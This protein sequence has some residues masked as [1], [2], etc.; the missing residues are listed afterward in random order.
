MRLTDP[1]DIFVG[2]TGGLRP[3][4]GTQ[5]IAGGT[6]S[7]SVAPG[8]IGS[9]GTPTLATPS[10]S[11]GNSGPFAVRQI[12]FTAADLIGPGGVGKTDGTSD[13]TLWL[14]AGTLSQSTG[15]AMPIFLQMSH[16]LF[17]S[18]ETGITGET[19]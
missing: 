10:G 5:L 19:P 13:L 12:S 18:A 8:A 4:L 14:K 16:G 3:D 11:A 7:F 1:A 2:E 15:S 17:L 9:L 6:M